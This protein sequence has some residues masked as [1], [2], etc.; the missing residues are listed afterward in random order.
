MLRAF[1]MKKTH[2]LAIF[3]V[4]VSAILFTS[5]IS[6]VV[7]DGMNG[8]MQMGLALILFCTVPAIIRKKLPDPRVWIVLMV[9][10]AVTIYGALTSYNISL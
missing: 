9:G 7:L 6:E 1:L 5:G 3:I 8:W 2:L 10:V 4:S